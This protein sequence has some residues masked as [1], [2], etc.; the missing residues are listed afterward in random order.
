VLH[1]DTA[2]PQLA[3]SLKGS[4]YFVVSCDEFSSYTQ[5]R[6]VGVKSEITD[7]VK[8]SVSTTELETRNKI[9]RLHADNGTEFCSKNLSGFLQERG[10]IHPTSAPR[11]PEQNGLAERRV[12]TMEDCA[13]TLLIDSQ[14]PDQFLAEAV[15]TAVHVQNRT[16]VGSGKI[17]TPYELWHK[18]EP[19]LQNLHRFGEQVVIREPNALRWDVRGSVG[20]FV[21][22]TDVLNT[23]RVYK[24]EEK[25]VFRS[26]DVNF[27]DSNR[28]RSTYAELIPET[29]GRK[30]T[31]KLSMRATHGKD[32]QIVIH[33]GVWDNNTE[34]GKETINVAKSIPL[35]EDVQ[36]LRERYA[37][38]QDQ[39]LFATMVLNAFYRAGQRVQAIINGAEDVYVDVWLLSK[40]SENNDRETCSECKDKLRLFDHR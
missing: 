30:K 24:P 17:A 16:L 3:E 22:Y 26:R 29:S 39:A 4:K 7:Q 34:I 19:N 6:F 2:G 36:G 10:I 1:L 27:V 21:G 15:H 14:S 32:K 35:D 12:R 20:I 8:L 37:N 13:R 25:D 18:C 38:S 11:M 40:L 28:V 23:F 31:V 5:V 33:E 9:L